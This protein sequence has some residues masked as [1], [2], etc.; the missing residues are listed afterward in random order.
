M[1]ILIKNKF[2]GGGRLPLLPEPNVG[3]T[4]GPYGDYC[5]EVASSLD[6]CILRILS[7]Q[8][9]TVYLYPVTSHYLLSHLDCIELLPSYGI[10]AAAAAGYAPVICNPRGRG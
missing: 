3:Q 9:W 5:A 4:F 1:K 10:K 2:W 6:P 7:Q 8:L